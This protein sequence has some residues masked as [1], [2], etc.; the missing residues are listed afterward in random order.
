MTS[1][2][3]ADTGSDAAAGD[4]DGPQPKHVR[5]REDLRHRIRAQARR[6][7]PRLPSEAALVRHYGVSRITVRQALQALAHEGLIL[8]VPGKGSFVAG[9]RPYQQLSQL[10]GLAEAMR[11]QGRT[12]LN[13]VLQVARTGIEGKQ[14]EQLRLA[15][16]STVTHIRRVR[17]IDGAPASLDVSWLPLDIGERLETAALETRDVFAVIEQDLATPLGHADLAFDAVAAPA[18]VARELG[19]HAGTPLLFVERLTHDRH[20]RPIDLEHLYCRGD[21]FQLRLRI[22]RQEGRPQ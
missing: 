18:A 6:G 13:R 3:Q 5:V 7:S 19:V 11:A 20:G 15:P 22:D 16:G 9:E 17:L 10:Q 12:V 2:D 21:R 8:R 1:P 4:D 14:A